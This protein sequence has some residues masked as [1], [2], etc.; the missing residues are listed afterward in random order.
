MEKKKLSDYIKSAGQIFTAKQLGVTQGAVSHMV[1][2]GREV[3]LQ[4]NPAG[5]VTDAF[6]V[7]R[8]GRFAK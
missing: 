3:Y 4:V 8:I 5:E 7:K 6:E 1:V 2:N